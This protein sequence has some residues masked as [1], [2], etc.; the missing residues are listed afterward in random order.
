M[1]VNLKKSAIMFVT[2]RRFKQKKHSKKYPETSSYKHLGTMINR[3]GSLTKHFKST[4]MNMVKTAT[5]LTRIKND[6]VMPK[7][8]TQLYFIITK[9]TL[10]YPGPILH[11][12]TEGIKDRFRKLAYKTLRQILGLRR[13]SPI[14][15]LHQLCGDPAEEWE[16][17]NLYYM[18]G[19]EARSTDT[20][21]I[22]MVKKK[23]DRVRIRK[24]LSWPALRLACISLSAKGNCVE[25]GEE[26]VL[27]A[28][29]TKHAGRD[30]T[31]FNTIL[32]LIKT[33]DSLS[34]LA[35]LDIAILKRCWI[36]YKKIFKFKPRKM[37]INLTCVTIQGEANNI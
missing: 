5:A 32:E 3:K 10:D 20:Q 1:E 25:C 29:I 13:S 26:N 19:K 36:L 6:S 28:H 4:A 31:I 15:V 24:Y 37:G 27:P 2:K 23:R 8:L 16:R 22:E 14:K 35:G 11:N 7:R 17:R 18:I 12:Q 33:E 21:Y 34:N 9:A 30:S